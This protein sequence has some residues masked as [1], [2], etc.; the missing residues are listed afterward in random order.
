MS[1]ADRYKGYRDPCRAVMQRHGIRV[2]SEVRAETTRG[3]FEGLVLPRSETRWGS[4]SRF[5]S[6][7]CATRYRPWGRCHGHPRTASAHQNLS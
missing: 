1:D 3:N 7:R 5:S 4:P 2:W 6:I